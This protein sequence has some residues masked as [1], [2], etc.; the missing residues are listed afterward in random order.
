VTS[1]ALDLGQAVV[2]G[3][4]SFGQRRPHEL[5]GAVVWCVAGADGRFCAGVRFEKPLAYGD[6]QGLTY[7]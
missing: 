1:E 4:Q 6:L 5:P 3:L 2:I 7:L